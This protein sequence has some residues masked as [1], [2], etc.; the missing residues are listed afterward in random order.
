[1]LTQ[2]YSPRHLKERL[3]NNYMPDPI[4]RILSRLEPISDKVVRRPLAEEEILALEATV[5][6]PLPACVRDYFRTIG[7]FQ[8]LTAYGTADYEVFDHLDQFRKQR[9]YLTANFDKS[10]VNLFP[11]A[12]DGAG[13]V[14]AVAGGTENDTLFFADH[15]THELRRIGSFCDWLSSV[16]DAA[17]NT[18]RPANAEK[19]WCV[20]FSFRVSGPE[21]IL[22]VIR[23]FGAV[24]MGEWSDPKTLPSKVNSSEAPLDF[25]NEELILKRSQY[26][27]WEQPMFAFDYSEPV[28]LPP[29]ASVIRKLDASFQRAGLAYKLVDYR[30]LS[31]EW[32]KPKSADQ[33]TKT[34]LGKIWSRLTS[35][36]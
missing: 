27:T 7:L 32:R 11:F 24:N 18:E 4:R 10:T 23:Q 9:E 29:S 2:I 15:E 13:N 19:K 28:D 1:M 33:T 16:V 21:P 5:D 20:Q 6:M 12:D 34:P 31:L 25:A 17:L 36:L 26:H 35:P 3:N 30:P 8:D 22:T 14:I